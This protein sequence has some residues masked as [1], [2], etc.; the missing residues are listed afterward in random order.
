MNTQADRNPRKA[1][2]KGLSALLP[3]RGQGAAPAP[4]PAPAPQPS[5]RELPEH[6]EAFESLP[7]DQILPGTE[8][9]RTKFD[10]ERLNELAESIRANGVIQPITVRQEVGGR[11]RIIAGERRWRAAQIAGLSSIPALVRSADEHQRLE[12][13]LIENL[14]REDL[15]P[16]E[17][18]TAFQ[19]LIDEHKF[20]HEQIA[21]RTGKDRSTV[22][23]LLRLLRSS[24]FVRSALIDGSITMGHARALLNVP[25]EDA[26]DYLCREV[27]EKQYSVRQTESMVRYVEQEN[28]ASQAQAA[29]A[30]TPTRAL[31][32]VDNED[33]PNIRAA[34][35]DLEAALGTRVR[36][37][38]KPNG[39]GRLEIEFYSADDLDRIYS[40]IIKEN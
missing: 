2:G 35:A 4:I 31:A 7:L 17:V 14:Q 15:N 26:Q 37:T 36:L 28:G 18:A 1:L 13:A 40:V 3:T 9:P 38:R 11:Y 19:R 5:H 6:F 33:D 24:P 16:I 27:I 20:S 29:P 23:N 39:A 25:G 21:Q 34:I 8:Q 32:A 30:A 22:T 12:L 10:K